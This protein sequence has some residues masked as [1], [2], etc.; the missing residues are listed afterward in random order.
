MDCSL[1]KLMPCPFFKV[2]YLPSVWLIVLFFPWEVWHN[3]FYRLKQCLSQ[4]CVYSISCSSFPSARC[5]L[6]SGVCECPAVMG[7]GRQPL[8]Q[9]SAVSSLSLSSA[10]LHVFSPQPHRPS[11]QPPEASREVGLVTSLIV[12]NSFLWKRTVHCII[13]SE[14]KLSPI[15][16]YYCLQSHMLI[17]D[18]SW[19]HKNNDIQWNAPHTSISHIV[20]EY[21][22]CSVHNF[23][24]FSS[25]GLSLLL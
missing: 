19:T 25:P 20:I 4:L 14:V 23:D 6:F 22:Q 21:L 11:P 17:L 9:F 2:C 24:V 16:P 5:V 13:S 3:N 1:R 7:L 15:R 10:D 18:S 12:N 8:G